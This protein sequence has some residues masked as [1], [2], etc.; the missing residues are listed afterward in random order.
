MTVG[1]LDH[2]VH[3]LYIGS[4]MHSRPLPNISPEFSVFD[5]PGIREY[6]VENWHLSRAGTGG[7]VNG[8]SIFG[9]QDLLIV[10]GFLCLVVV[11]I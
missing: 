8:A 7:V 3:V 10:I 6:R 9:W 5:F 4:S 2:E 1:A 11:C